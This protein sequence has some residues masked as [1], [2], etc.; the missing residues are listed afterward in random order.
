M[1]TDQMRMADQTCLDKFDCLVVDWSTPTPAW[2]PTRSS[3][4]PTGAEACMPAIGTDSSRRPIT[5]AHAHARSAQHWN[6]AV[7][8][9][10]YYIQHFLQALPQRP[11]DGNDAWPPIQLGQEPSAQQTQHTQHMPRTPRTSLLPVRHPFSAAV[12]TLDLSGGSGGPGAAGGMHALSASSRGAGEAGHWGVVI[13][14]LVAVAAVLAGAA[15][16]AWSRH[17]DWRQPRRRL[18]REHSASHTPQHRALAPLNCCGVQLAEVGEGD[19]G[20]YY[21]LEVRHASP[22]RLP[23]AYACMALLA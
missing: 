16:V 21:S 22:P 1:R 12:P 19:V 20:V 9:S 7:Q 8:P 4:A 3:S 15:V 2:D 6:A 18:R 14:M 10:A 13:G 23:F 5:S 17:P 11:P